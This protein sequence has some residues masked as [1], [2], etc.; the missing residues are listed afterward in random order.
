MAT[1][2]RIM[3]V[4]DL[5]AKSKDELL[6]LA[7]ESGIADGINRKQAPICPPLRK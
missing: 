6:V 2:Q 1:T 3:E 7:H 4:A 5:G